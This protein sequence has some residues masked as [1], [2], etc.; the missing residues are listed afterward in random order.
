MDRVACLRD[1]MERRQVKCERHGVPHLSLNGRLFVRRGQVISVSGPDCEGATLSRDDCQFLLKRLGGSMVRWTEG[2]EPSGPT[3][4]YSVICRRFLPVE[5]MAAK[6]RSEVRRGLKGCEARR[7]TAMELADAGY[8]VFRNAESRYGTPTSSIPDQG[9]FRH[10]VA[11]ESEYPDLVENWGVYA[12][13]RMIAFAQ[14]QIF[15]LTE[16][17]YSSIRLDPD[18]LDR[19]PAYALVYR[20]NEHYLGERGFSYVNDGFRNVLHATNVQRFL[21]EKFGFEKAYSRLRVHFASSLGAA[22]RGLYPLRGVVGKLG[23]E[24]RALLEMERCRRAT[25]GP[26]PS[27]DVR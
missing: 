15:G 11:R 27:G 6:R 9:T 5:E 7:I 19:Y 4:W 24:I 25:S 17:N 16:V 20:M 26:R 23:P 8:H 18:S 10:R 22:V 21:M 3:E 13:G 14:N 12:D 1:S 2:F